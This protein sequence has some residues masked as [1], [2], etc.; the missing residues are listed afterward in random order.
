MGLEPPIMPG[1]LPPEGIELSTLVTVGL[2]CWSTVGVKLGLCL[3][4]AYLA[5]NSNNCLW[6][7]TM[8]SCCGERVDKSGMVDGELMV[9]A[10]GWPRVLAR[11][12]MGWG[13][14]AMDGGIFSI[15]RRHGQCDAWLLEG[16]LCATESTW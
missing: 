1:T 9:G 11:L 8:D 10:K 16:A 12:A 4:A 7:L 6:A 13:R 15:T 14:C 2:E 3:R 5:C